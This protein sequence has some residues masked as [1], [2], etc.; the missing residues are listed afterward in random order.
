MN[1]FE[2]LDEVFIAKTRI[3]GLSVSEY[4]VILACVILTQCQRV[5]DRERDGQADRQTDIPTVANTGLCV[6]MTVKHQPT[7]TL[8]CDDAIV[9]NSISM[10]CLLKAGNR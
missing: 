7:V 9:P 8:N 10:Y 2:F 3:L 5:T 1:R 6:D 4:F